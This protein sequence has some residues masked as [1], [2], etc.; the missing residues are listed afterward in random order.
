MDKFILSYVNLPETDVRLDM[1]FDTIDLL[2]VFVNKS[3][4]TRTSYQIIV[5]RK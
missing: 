1:Q 3:F 5:V 4:P 2:I